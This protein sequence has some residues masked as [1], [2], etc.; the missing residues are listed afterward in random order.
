VKIAAAV[1]AKVAP[2]AIKPPPPVAAKPAAAPAIVKKEL[3]SPPSA[4]VGLA[5]AAPL[6]LAPVPAKPAPPSAPAAATG[7][8]VLQI[9]AYKSQAEADGAWKAYKA[10][11]AA[12]LAEASEDV[13]QA[14][15]GDKGTWY[16]LRLVGFP[17]KDV[18]LAMCDR[19]KADGGGCF[20]G[21]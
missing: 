1:P 6:S 16:R 8:S 10:K 12:L 13:Q 15:L 5:T 7:G 20:L 4:P 18:A 11:H 9:G 14:D 19:L 21:K 17:S 3:P 2:A